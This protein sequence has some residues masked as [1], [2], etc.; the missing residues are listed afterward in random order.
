[1][2]LSK[3]NISPNVTRVDNNANRDADLIKTPPSPRE[4]RE[5]I[6]EH[7][8]SNKLPLSSDGAKAILEQVTP[9]GT[10]ARV[11]G[12]NVAGP[13]IRIVNSANFDPVTTVQVKSVSNARNFETQVLEDLKKKISPDGGSQFIAVQVPYGSNVSQLQ[14]KLGNFSSERVGGRSIV[15]VDEFGNVLIPL[16][17]LSNFVRKP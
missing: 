15:V 8:K 6:D 9:M 1:L 14:G 11:A 17:P 4:I 13:D 5:L 7:S 16:Q 3:K 2:S 12:D 10:T